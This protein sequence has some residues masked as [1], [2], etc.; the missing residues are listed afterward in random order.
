MMEDTDI[1]STFQM[2]AQTVAEENPVLEQVPQLS[3][4]AQLLERDQ[5]EMETQNDNLEDNI[6]EH[7]EAVDTPQVQE[8]QAQP[9]SNQVAMKFLSNL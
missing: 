3:G 1:A 6:N 2:P 7:R 8:T 9:D 4:R 5:T